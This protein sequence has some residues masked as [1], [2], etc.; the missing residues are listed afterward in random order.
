MFGAANTVTA[1]TLPH[2]PGPDSLT[3][4]V[5]ADTDGVLH[6]CLHVSSG[7]STIRGGGGDKTRSGRNHGEFSDVFEEDQTVRTTC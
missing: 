1:V 4:F 7:K 3:P 6:C 2:K 5:G